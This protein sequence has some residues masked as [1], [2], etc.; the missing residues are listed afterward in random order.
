MTKKYSDLSPLTLLLVGVLVILLLAVPIL[1][2]AYFFH[3]AGFPWDVAWDDVWSE[4]QVRFAKSLGT[5]GFF[6]TAPALL[7]IPVALKHRVVAALFALAMATTALL[8]FIFGNVY[9]L[10]PQDVGPYFG[11]GLFVLVGLVLLPS[12]VGNA[13]SD[14]SPP[15]VLLVVAALFLIWCMLLALKHFGEIAVITNGAFFA[16]SDLTDLNFL[17]TYSRHFLPVFSVLM[18]LIVVP[19]VWLRVSWVPR[20]ALTFAASTLIAMGWTH[21]EFADTS[22]RHVIL[23][24]I[25]L[26][27]A[28]LSWLTWHS[29]RTRK[30]SAPVS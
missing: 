23:P 22:L 26:G 19:L 10:L 16:Y 17:K 5:W 3:A 27:M 29:T 6:W 2:K 1:S 9:G 14:R 4:L 13:A 12:A 8:T 24:W 18:G 20:Y 7:I 11:A 21:S 30:S 15:A 28:T 25:V